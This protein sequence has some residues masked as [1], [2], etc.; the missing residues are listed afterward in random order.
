M[1]R[2]DWS[3]GTST[4]HNSCQLPCTYNGTKLKEK[5]LF[6]VHRRAYVPRILSCMKTFP[7]SVRSIA[8]NKRQKFVLK[9]EMVFNTFDVISS[10]WLLTIYLKIVLNCV[11]LYFSL[12]SSIVPKSIIEIRIF[13]VKKIALNVKI[14]NF[15]FASNSVNFFP[16]LF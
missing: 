13:N 2:V 10:K 11:Q 5:L 4:W 12:L 16:M 9:R 7:R 3:I 8:S 15:S 14:F 1:T 6:R